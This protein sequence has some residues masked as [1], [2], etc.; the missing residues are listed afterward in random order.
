M[1]DYFWVKCIDCSCM[2]EIYFLID[3]RQNW[4][5]CWKTARIYWTPCRVIMQHIWTKGNFWIRFTVEHIKLRYWTMWCFL[6]DAFHLYLSHIGY[7][8]TLLNKDL[9]SV[10][11]YQQE[12][13]VLCKLNLQHQ[14]RK[15]IAMGPVNKAM[16][17]MNNMADLLVTMNCR[18]II[19]NFQIIVLSLCNKTAYT[20]VFFAATTLN[21]LLITSYVAILLRLS[22][23]PSDN[24][25]NLYI[26]KLATKQ[27]LLKSI[28]YFAC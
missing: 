1:Q 12:F 2:V 4:L 18:N 5:K 26:S 9:Y 23:L 13:F 11:T 22:N 20:K 15:I 21:Y 19:L 3:H 7:L 17:N 27:V 24:C 14:A 8:Q 10:Q 28:P 25:F 16:Y 6:H